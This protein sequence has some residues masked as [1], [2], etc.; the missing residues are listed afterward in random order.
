MVRRSVSILVKVCPAG[1]TEG[2]RYVLRC[3]R[4]LVRSLI[5]SFSL[6]LAVSRFFPGYLDLDFFVMDNVAAEDPERG[7]SCVPWVRRGTA[8]LLKTKQ[9]VAFGSLPAAWRE[10]GEKQIESTEEVGD[11][12]LLPALK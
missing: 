9:S 7:V 10:A 2:G 1:A 5:L 4:A 12:L 6:S 8:G 11:K 3:C